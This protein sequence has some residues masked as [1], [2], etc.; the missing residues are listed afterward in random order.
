MQAGEDAV[1]SRARTCGRRDGEE[2]GRLR[3]RRISEQN[4]DLLQLQRLIA[5][6]D[7]IACRR[8]LEYRLHLRGRQPG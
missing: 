6:L 1:E 7:D 5:Q 8:L 3:P 4:A 2:S